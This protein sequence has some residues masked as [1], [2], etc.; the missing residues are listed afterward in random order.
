MELL[1]GLVSYIDHI[2]QKN[3]VVKMVT[4]VF[5]IL[6]LLVYMFMSDQIQNQDDVVIIYDW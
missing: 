6:A 1:G 5:S 3:Q 2:S 4:Q